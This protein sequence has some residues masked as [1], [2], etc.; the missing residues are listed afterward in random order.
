MEVIGSIALA[1]LQS[2][3]FY[4]KEIGISMFLF[5]IIGC[6]IL[7]YILKKKNKIENKNGFFFIIPILL[8][9]SS[10][11]IMAN[12]TFYLVN[13]GI[14]LVLD[15]MM[16]VVLTHKKDYLKNHIIRS[17]MLITDILSDYGE[18]LEYT[19]KILKEKVNHQDKIE[20][21]MLKRIGVSIAIVFCVV[22]VVIM[23]L[24]SADSI[25][26]SLFAGVGDV[27]HK[28][29]IGSL[30]SLI[31]RVFIIGVTYILFL[32]I[33][34]EMQEKRDLEN[35]EE[36]EERSNKKYGFTIKLLLITLNIV[37]FI[38]SYIQIQSL[39]AKINIG[40]T[41][42]YAQ[43]ARSGF[44]QLMFVSLINFVLILVSNKYSDS[45]E[46]MIK[47]LNVLL[48]VFTIIIVFSSMYRM[49][50]YEMEYGLTYLRMFVYIILITELAVLVPVIFYLWGAKFDVMKCSMIIL[51]AVYCI[52]N[53]INIE[54][55][56]VS[57]NIN[58][59][60]SD[61]PVD[62][63]YL[64]KIASEDSYSILEEKLKEHISIEEELKITKILLN[65]AQ[66]Q[67]EGKWQEFNI[68]KMKLRNKKIDIE[69]L[70]DRKE[71]L[72]S[73]ILKEAEN[74]RLLEKTPKDY[75]YLETI[76]KEKYLVEEIDRAMGNARWS[77]SKRTEGERYYTKIN[78][79]AV[80]TPSK[81][82]FFEN[83]L[84]FLERPVSIYCGASELLVTYDS[85]KT[86]E[87]ISFPKGIFTLSNPEGAQWEECYDYFYLPTK[88][89]DGTLTVL[90]SGGYEGG[91]NGGKTRAKYTSKDNGHTW[92]FASE[93]WKEIQ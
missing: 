52:I 39:F 60:E 44:F 51:L 1:I 79:I 88:E 8:L 77:I 46:K 27:F 59:L 82:K 9:S 16:I 2:I 24:A 20:K 45:K 85:G 5:E 13:I 69:K 47:I 89:S 48:I 75:I 74:T 28:I 87:P 91:Y 56:I 35:R 83:G 32:N 84:G 57:K 12:K 31:I 15:M 10:Y 81:I 78:E 68:S 65:I 41:F 67:T 33:M 18:G 71:E 38:F 64:S 6:G 50:M 93:I 58:R 26:A 70:G 86:F 36:K 55:I 4:G 14:I 23:L 61:T 37:Y 43:Y 30:G 7:C 54:K 66:H 63:S 72:E 92:E 25:F 80:T 3:L 22:S 73:L 49:H 90:V 11:F 29:N 17:L 62:Y 40:E 76:G 53:Y 21:G 42:N 34:I 19:K